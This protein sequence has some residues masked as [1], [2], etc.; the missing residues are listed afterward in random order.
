[1]RRLTLDFV[2]ICDRMIISANFG[3]WKPFA[4]K[5]FEQTI[6]A[7]RKFPRPN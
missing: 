4:E 7:K 6:L 2:V 5:N 1:M 3:S